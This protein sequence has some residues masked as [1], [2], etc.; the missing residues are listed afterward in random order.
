VT[1]PAAGGVAAPA[2]VAGPVRTIAG[3][4]PA[5]SVGPVAAVAVPT[6]GSAPAAAPSAAVATSLPSTGTGPDAPVAGLVGS[7]LL[8]VASGLA[9]F[10][11]L[12]VGRRSGSTR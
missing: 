6:E 2:P 7:L 8:L 11:A 3:P 1:M 10:G 9:G 4:A 12:Q 5:P